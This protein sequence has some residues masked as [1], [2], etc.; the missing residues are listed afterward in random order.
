ML[1]LVGPSFQDG[2]GAC[3]WAYSP[4]ARIVGVVVVVIVV[5]PIGLDWAQP[6]ALSNSQTT[7]GTV[8]CD[9]VKKWETKVSG[10]GQE[11]LQ[12]LDFSKFPRQRRKIATKVSGIHGQADSSIPAIPLNHSVHGDIPQGCLL[13]AAVAPLRPS[14]PGILLRRQ[15]QPQ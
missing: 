12:R 8:T 13:W 5:L 3:P 4:E 10:A 11:G 1:C 15:S 9:R 2:S 7:L 6:W 14:Q